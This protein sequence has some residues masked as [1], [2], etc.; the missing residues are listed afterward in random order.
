MSPSGSPFIILTLFG[1]S[2]Y[3]LLINSSGIYLT[4]VDRINNSDMSYCI[5]NRDGTI[6]IHR[7]GGIRLGY[8]NYNSDNIITYDRE[9]GC[10][11]SISESESVDF[12]IDS[13]T[14]ISGISYSMKSSHNPLMIAVND[15]YL[16]I[17]NMKILMIPINIRIPSEVIS[18]TSIEV[19]PLDDE[20]YPLILDPIH[21]KYDRI[22]TSRRIIIMAILIVILSIYI[23]ISRGIS[24]LKIL[25]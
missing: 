25:Y 1:D 24:K 10:I 6:V 15:D 5:I 21:N 8:L 9:A 12:H 17:T 14:K 11:F 22:I 23:L 20:V 2:C 16:D 19:E 4:S 18:P 7:L 13:D 3:I